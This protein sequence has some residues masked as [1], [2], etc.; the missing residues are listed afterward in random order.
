MTK[1]RAKKKTNRKPI[2][3]NNLGAHLTA[4]LVIA[5]ALLNGCSSLPKQAEKTSP[6]LLSVTPVEIS[7][8]Q[9]QQCQAKGYQ[10][11][12][13]SSLFQSAEAV[14]L[15]ANSDFHRAL[16]DSGA[17][18]YVRNDWKWRT[19]TWQPYYITMLF[20][21][22]ITV[23]RAGTGFYCPEPLLKQSQP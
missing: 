14:R 9:S 22:Q 18:A 12:K 10:R 4:S 15:K 23:S 1:K 11:K 5:S 17:N 20:Q 6:H 13:A 2:T 21:Q 3:M 7:E 19:E 16:V 8:Q